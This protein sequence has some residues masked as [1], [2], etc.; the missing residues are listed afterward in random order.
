MFKSLENKFLILYHRGNNIFL[1][2]KEIVFNFGDDW[3]VKGKCVFLFR[4]IGT[5][6]REEQVICINTLR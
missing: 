5:E 4:I 1:L 2:T 6:P 3:W